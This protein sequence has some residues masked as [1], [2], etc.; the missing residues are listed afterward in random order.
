MFKLTGCR[1]LAFHVLWQHACDLQVTRATRTQAKE[2]QSLCHCSPRLTIPAKPRAAH[3]RGDA[4]THKAPEMIGMVGRSIKSLPPTSRGHHHAKEAGDKYA[5][6]LMQSS[7]WRSHSVAS[8]LRARGGVT[9][10]PP[11]S[12]GLR[13]EQSL[14]RGT[15]A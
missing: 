1:C 9:M 3:K 11:A 4:P 8:H 7:E 6:T 12:H 13:F 5:A 10:H 2:P 15:S 14:L